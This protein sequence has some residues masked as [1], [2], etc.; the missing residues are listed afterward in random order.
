M[1][2]QLQVKGERSALQRTGKG[3]C[4]YLS[5]PLSARGRSGGH[6]NQQHQSKSTQCVAPSKAVQ[7]TQAGKLPP[8]KSNSRLS[9]SGEVQAVH[10][11]AVQSQT[12]GSKME[13]K[14]LVK[15]QGVYWRQGTPFPFALH[16]EPHRAVPLGS[17]HCTYLHRRG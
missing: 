15:P 13:K 6:I 4:L 8:V 5:L 12:A 14:P 16:T 3:W 2:Q 9:F 11:G 17:P 1:E 10:G 7:T